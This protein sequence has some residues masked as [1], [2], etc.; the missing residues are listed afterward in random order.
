MP[1]SSGVVALDCIRTDGRR[2]DCGISH[3]MEAARESLYSR[4]YE[5]MH[6]HSIVRV[7]GDS[8]Y[9][10]V[11]VRRRLSVVCLCFGCQDR[12]GRCGLNVMAR[13]Y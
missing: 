13:A 7:S 10:V 8:L 4:A 11:R 2:E 12:S 3:V 1:E 5:P 6:S 9:V